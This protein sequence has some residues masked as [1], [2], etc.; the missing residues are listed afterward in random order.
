[1]NYK[2]P[3]TFGPLAVI[4]FL[5]GLSKFSN[6][7]FSA[8]NAVMIITDPLIRVFYGREKFSIPPV[9]PP[10]GVLNNGGYQSSN[11]NIK[12]PGIPAKVIKVPPAVSFGNIIISAGTNKGV[13]SG[14][15]AVIENNILVGIVDE[16]FSGYSRLRLLSGFGKLEQVR[17]ENIGLVT[18]EGLGGAMFKIELPQDTNVSVGAPVT[19]NHRDYSYFAGLIDAVTRS[20]TKPLV[21][22]KAILPFNVYELNTVFVVP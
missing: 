3:K 13:S 8:S 19:F 16:A 5:I 21:D 14:M 10:A 4:I 9:D 18:A 7:E 17:I 11:T 6:I 1:M 22:A 2:L 12:S 15:I 20:G